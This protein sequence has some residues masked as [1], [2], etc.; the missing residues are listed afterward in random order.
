MEGGSEERSRQRTDDCSGL[1]EAS[2]AFP[3]REGLARRAGREEDVCAGGTLSDSFAARA[4]E[5]FIRKGLFQS[6]RGR[7]GSQKKAGDRKG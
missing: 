5:M 4:W 7:H 3:P 6:L 1:T 2:S